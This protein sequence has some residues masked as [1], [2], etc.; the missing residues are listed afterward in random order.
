MFNRINEEL[1]IKTNK[2]LKDA[3][4]DIVV[5]LDENEFFDTGTISNILRH[6]YNIYITPKLLE[7]FLTLWDQNKDSIFSFE[8]DKWLSWDSTE[9]IIEN[10][11]S[12]K[13]RGIL[14]K[15]RRKLK[16]KEEEE[17]YDIV[18]KDG[19]VKL[20]DGRFVY[21]GSRTFKV[22]D[23]EITRN[24][25]EKFQYNKGDNPI[26]IEL[27]Y[28]V[29]DIKDVTDAYKIST[30]IDNAIKMGE[31]VSNPKIGDAYFDECFRYLLSIAEKMKIEKRKYWEENA[32]TRMKKRLKRRR[33]RLEYEEEQEQKALETLIKNREKGLE[34]LK[35]LIDINEKYFL[36]ITKYNRKK[37]IFMIKNLIYGYF[38]ISDDKYPDGYYKIVIRKEKDGDDI[39]FFNTIRHF[40]MCLES[41]LK[42]EDMHVFNIIDKDNIKK[43]KIYF[44]ELKRFK[45]WDEYID[46][47]LSDK[48]KD[49]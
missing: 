38:T 37:Q 35:K 12:K 46:K 26:T 7:R 21:K 14:G 39:I 15:S 31:I 48:L 30:E 44:N 22:D 27:I 13:K 25:F 33:K 29:L 23:S 4:H 45:G 18:K 43:L 40:E 47:D 3:I 42:G 19:W 8:D 32:P 16:R 28:N 2:K 20:R 6:Q 41:G 10:N 24:K 34:E 5:T 36:I 17:F 9:K 49:L 11:L 1:K